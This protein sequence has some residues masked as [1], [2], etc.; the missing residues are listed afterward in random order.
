MIEHR[1]DARSHS[2]FA[3]QQVRIAMPLRGW[4]ATSLLH[5]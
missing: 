3:I 4:R 5:G 2:T 1:S